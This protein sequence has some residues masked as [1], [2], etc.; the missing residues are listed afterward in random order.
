MDIEKV[1][2]YGDGIWYEVESED[3]AHDIAAQTQT[4][5]RVMRD[6][7]WDEFSPVF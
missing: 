4:S 7:Q 5:Y 1:E 3:K 6:G 2:V